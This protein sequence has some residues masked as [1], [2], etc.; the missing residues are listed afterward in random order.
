MGRAEEQRDKG[1]KRLD[2]MAAKIYSN[3]MTVSVESIAQAAAGLSPSQKLDLAHRI[4]AGMETADHETA[5][6]AWDE[7]IRERRTRYET[8]EAET[9]SV[10]KTFAEVKWRLKVK[11]HS[12]AAVATILRR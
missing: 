12:L 3:P 11:D 5:E 7:L 9:F 10:E 2:K 4:L 1:V 8:G 6:A